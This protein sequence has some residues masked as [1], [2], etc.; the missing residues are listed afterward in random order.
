MQTA[1]DDDAIQ[2]VDVAILVAL[3]LEAAPLLESIRDRV[4]LKASSG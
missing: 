3:S 1:F 2:R 4:Q